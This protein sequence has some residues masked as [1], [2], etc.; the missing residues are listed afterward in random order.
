MLDQSIKAA[1]A[2]RERGIGLASLCCLTVAHAMLSGDSQFTV[3]LGEISTALI[4]GVC[5]LG[6]GFSTI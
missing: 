3:G 4:P 5:S 2:D 1:N 6:P